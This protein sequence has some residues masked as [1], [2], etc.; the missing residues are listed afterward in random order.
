MSAWGQKTDACSALADVCF[1]SNAD[2]CGAK[3]DVR[4]SLI[5]TNCI[6][7]AMCGMP[8]DGEPQNAC[9]GFVSGYKYRD[10]EISQPFAFSGRLWSA[11]S[12]FA[13]SS[14]S[15][16]RTQNKKEGAELMLDVC[17][18]VGARRY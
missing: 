18:A 6:I 7:S 4:F 1:G 12:I 10:P 14:V 8:E 5:T 11:A 9:A 15:L 3:S 13:P 17:R 2:M 16:K